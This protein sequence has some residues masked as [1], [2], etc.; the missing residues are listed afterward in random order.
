MEFSKIIISAIIAAVLNS[1]AHSAPMHNT[2]S[3]VE[4]F[5]ISVL[6]SRV[7][8]ATQEVL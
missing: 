1:L 7:T 3:P 6:P 4:L 5:L 2:P 8:N